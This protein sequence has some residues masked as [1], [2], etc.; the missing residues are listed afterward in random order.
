MA[1]AQE[2]V[3][4]IL[5]SARKLAFKTP[6]D[7]CFRTSETFI[8]FYKTATSGIYFAMIGIA[9]IA[10]L[11]GG[12]VVMNIMLVSVTERIKEIGVRMAVGAKRRD[13]LVQFLIESSA[14]SAVG[15]VI[16]IVLGIA[17]AQGISAATS[18]P[19]DGRSRFRPPR[20][21]DVVLP[22]ALFRHL[23]R[24][25]GGQAQPGRRPE[26]G[27]MIRHGIFRE[28]LAMAFDSLRSHK[29]RSFL[30]LLGVMIGV[31][32]VIGMVSIIQGLNASFMKELQAAGSDLIIIHKYNPVQMRQL[33]EEERHREDLT[34][35]D[36][37]A[38][39]RE[40]PLVKAVSANMN[41]PVFDDVKVKFQN[42]TA[43]GAIVIGI[44][45]K[46]PIVYNI[47]LPKEGRHLT[48]SEI[49][50][51]AR[52]CVLGSEAAETLFPHMCPVGKQVRIGPES[53]TVVGVL[54]KRGQIFGQSRDNF[55]GIPITTLMKT[56]PLPEGFARDRARA[57]GPRDDQGD[58]RAGHG[59]AP[60]QAEGSRRQAQR[61]RHLHPGLDARP[62][63]PDHRGGVPGDDRSSPRSASSW[64]GSGS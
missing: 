28:I 30:T 3:R 53:F 36:A 14:I 12:I 6:D 52:V 10:L 50:H 13:I 1:A 62:L 27:A 48:G 37:L 24:Q 11:V 35:E 25:Q 2:E 47:Y 17:L 45:D 43:E 20:R 29:L 22:R 40:C 59:Q 54:S 15:G 41:V 49:E 19:A 16:G 56:Y 51:N 32:T 33:T 7:F 38:I 63:Q 5:R 57:Q 42:A 21:R 31:M 26:V 9:S 39:E 60:A 23:P 61:F 8:Q 4:T 55:V 44:N 46:F 64:A 18:L 58:D 34:Y